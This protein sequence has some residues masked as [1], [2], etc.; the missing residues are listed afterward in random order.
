MGA[1]SLREVVRSEAD[2][3]KN[4]ASLVHVEAYDSVTAPGPV[5]ARDH[6]RRYTPRTIRRIRLITFR[7]ARGAGRASLT[8]AEGVQGRARIRAAHGTQYARPC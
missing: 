5:V 6:R 2:S 1:R 4:A 7:V 8:L 3:A